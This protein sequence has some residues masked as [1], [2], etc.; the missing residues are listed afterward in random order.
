MAAPRDSA[1]VTIQPFAAGDLSPV[2][3][4]W[5]RCL[6]KDPI[7]EERFWRLFLLDA[8][9]DPEGA[10]VARDGGGNVVGFLQAMARREPYGSLGLHE[11]QGWLTVFFVAPERRREGIGSRLLEAGLSFLRAKGRERVL[12]N[13]YAPY[14]IFPGVDVD[15]PEAGPFLEARGFQPASEAVAMGMPLEGARARMP[16]RVREKAAEM[17]REGYDVRPFRTDDTL[18]LF[19]F[20][21]EQFPHWEPSLRD[22]LLHGNTEVVLAT[23]RGAVVGYTQWQNPHND[24]PDGAP[25]RFGPFG[26]HPEYRGKGVGAVIFHTMVERAAGNGARYLWFGWA[27]GRNLSFY[28]RAGC[29][30]TRRFRLYSHVLT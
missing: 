25:C 8:N 21:R 3:V 16:E 30:V 1:S 22:G 12:C 29:A 7:T 24:P 10:L 17:T 27:G 2:V 4:L 20:V 15:Y 18:S 9:F 11:A 28:E 14:Y 5:N 26:V 13:G 6:T 23:H 19:A